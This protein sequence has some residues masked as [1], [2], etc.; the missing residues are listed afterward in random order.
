MNKVK[1]NRVL[2]VIA[3][4]LFSMAA[5][6]ALISGIVFIIAIKN[7][8][9]NENGKERVR[10]DILGEICYRYEDNAI[11]WYISLI[12]EDGY[13][14]DYEYDSFE[15]YFSEEN[16]N[17]FFTIEPVLEE[18]GEENYPTLDNYYTDDYQYKNS[19][20]H[21]ICYTGDVQTFTYKLSFEDL[22][23]NGDIHFYGV[24]QIEEEYYETTQVQNAEE[25]Y[26]TTR[27]QN[28]EEIPYTVYGDDGVLGR[29]DVLSYNVYEEGDGFTIELILDGG[30]I[31]CDINNGDFVASYEKFKNDL[32][33]NYNNIQVLDYYY[34]EN[35][36]DL[37]VDFVC[38]N[39]FEIKLTSYVKSDLT[40][41][42][43]FKSS[44]MLRYTT[45][46][47]D[48]ALPCLI[49]SVLMLLVTFVYMIVSAGHKA[50]E[51]GIY[52]CGFH[53]VPFDIVVGAY[54]VLIVAVICFLEEI[55][56]AYFTIMVT[57]LIAIALL[58]LVTPVMIYTVS[59]RIKKGNMFA[60]T[61][62]WKL[63]RWFGKTMGTGFK[64]IRENFNLYW[65]WIGA[66]GLL[67]LVELFICFAIA[68]IEGVM[69]LWFFEK[70]VF[71]FVFIIAIS[72]MQKLK[73]GANEIAKGNM[74]YTI[75]T[76]KMLWEF[77]AHGE[78]LN[79]IRDGI[80][81][82]VDERMKSEHMKT[83]LIT[84]VSHDIKTPLTSI[85]N[86]VDLL[87]KEEL[88]NE[89]AVEYL[90]V[91]DR[92]SA[93]LKKLIQDLI[94]ASK[95]STGNMKVDFAKV[96]VKVLIEQ[97]LGEFS[98]KL[99]EK[100]LT[101]VVNVR[102]ENTEVMA[103]G[104]HLWRVIDNLVSN[105]AKY[106]Q[107]GTRVYMDVARISLED[108]PSN[109]D[110]DSIISGRQENS[111][112]GILKVTFKN[113]S[114]EELNISGDELMERFV[115]GDKSRNT[116]GNGLGISIAKSLMK[117]QR[118]DLQIVVDGDLFKAELYLM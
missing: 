118:G 109:V 104:R 95:A 106:A 116:E 54:F 84:N 115:R 101:P 80:Q 70:I 2:K 16:T 77:K 1:E 45:K 8:Y 32:G 25:Y 112:D 7:D 79:C 36:E 74:A 18:T 105:I 43:D 37:M 61:L 87:S 114:K 96:D 97:S 51:E 58:A 71:S 9:Y 26:E 35:S 30:Y 75:N 46:V 66:Y 3:S 34:D 110:V 19:R 15:E 56:G 63:L 108:I 98:D 93:K 38:E 53:R 76:E 59:V 102:T 73:H 89:K 100:G 48:A 60:N 28:V 29:E 20:R 21:T 42:D 107:E 23:F 5:V 50:G 31:L 11:N 62:I 67:S 111:K 13:L 99:E 12:G 94:D 22:M 83:E 39:Y 41:Y 14:K 91:L 57:S 17:Y 68:D 27:V 6:M 47:L 49:I 86:Y 82:A 4:I 65:K 103:D 52:L 33:K 81:V 40:A 92:Q 113:I 64:Y 88:K 117:L 72:N 44:Y 24:E 90:E 69:L 10:E 85:I 78:N 55:T